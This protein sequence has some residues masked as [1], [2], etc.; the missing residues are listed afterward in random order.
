MI[1]LDIEPLV[2]RLGHVD[3][4]LVDVSVVDAEDLGSLCALE[5]VDLL[6]DLFS[7]RS[8]SLGDVVS[9]RECLVQSLLVSPL[10][11]GYG[12]MD[13]LRRSRLQRRVPRK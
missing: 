1:Y 9:V 2:Q 6:V 13:L 8:I 3:Q 12:Q 4:S 10:A 7:L 5:D 11:V